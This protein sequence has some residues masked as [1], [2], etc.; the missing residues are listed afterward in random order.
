VLGPSGGPKWYSGPTF[1]N[2]S[3]SDQWDGTYA[4]FSDTVKL[5]H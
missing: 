3:F 4:Y 2:I 5:H 1:L